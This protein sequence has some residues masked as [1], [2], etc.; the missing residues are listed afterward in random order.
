MRFKVSKPHKFENVGADLATHPDP[1]HRILQEL[2]R[3]PLDTALQMLF[4]LALPMAS[5]GKSET[6]Q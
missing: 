5:L 6:L 3:K 2:Y 4:P 1:D